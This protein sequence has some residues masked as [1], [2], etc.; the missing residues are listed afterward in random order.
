LLFDRVL[1]PFERLAELPLAGR[2][3]DPLD[4]RWLLGL[5]LGD[6]SERL[7]TCRVSR[8]G[9]GEALRSLFDGVWR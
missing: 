9:V 1:L 3:A 8:A 4:A 6:E 7:F 2:L 5:R